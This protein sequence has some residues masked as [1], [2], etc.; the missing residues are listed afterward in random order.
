MTPTSS[1]SLTGDAALA[2]KAA[3]NQAVKLIEQQQ[4]NNVSS[5]DASLPF[6]GMLSSEELAKRQ[7]RFDAEDAERNIDNSTFLDSPDELAVTDPKISDQASLWE[8]REAALY[9]PASGFNDYLAK[10][11]EE[12]DE[13]LEKYLTQRRITAA[14]ATEGSTCTEETRLKKIK[15]NETAMGKQR[16]KPLGIREPQ[17]QVQKKLKKQVQ[18]TVISGSPQEKQKDL[19]QLMAEFTDNAPKY[20]GMKQRDLPIAKIGFR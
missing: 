19:K 18:S 11:K 10:L 9:G 4:N 13:E 16:R 6:G 15:D 20:E 5:F 2:Q 12:T 8:N 1:L 3:Q 7:A 17:Y 14:P